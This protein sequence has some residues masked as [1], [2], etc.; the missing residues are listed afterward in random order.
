MVVDSEEFLSERS[1]LFYELQRS[2][3]NKA[4]YQVYLGRIAHFMNNPPGPDRQGVFSFD[5]K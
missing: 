3:D 5:K 4:L 2:C 1:R